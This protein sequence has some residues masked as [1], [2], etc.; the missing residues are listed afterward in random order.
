MVY[1]GFSWL[2]CANVHLITIFSD[3]PIHQTHLRPN[4]PTL[5]EV[6]MNFYTYFLPFKSKV[7][8]TKLYKLQRI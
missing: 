6:N 1:K 7:N 5:N 3:D 8:V 4:N 2:E